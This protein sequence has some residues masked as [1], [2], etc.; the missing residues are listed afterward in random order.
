MDPEECLFLNA[1]VVLLLCGIYFVYKVGFDDHK[2]EH[3]FKKYQSMTPMQ[4]LFA[5]WIGLA[6]VISS[7]VVLTMDKHYNTPLLNNML[8]KVIS[9]ILLLITGIIFFKE[10]YNYRQMFGMIMMIL[11]GVLVFYHSDNSSLLE[12]SKD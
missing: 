11:G 10:H 2:I 1:M 4:I 7:M 3:T 5:G 6:T 9:V 8:F 12:K